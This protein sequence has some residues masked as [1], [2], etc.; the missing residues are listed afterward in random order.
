[1]REQEPM[2][3]TLNVNDAE[4]DFANLVRRVSKHETRVVVEEGGT[5]MAAIVSTEDLSRLTRI[6]QLR[7]K[8][9]EV[10][11]EIHALNHDK[12][13]DEV[14]RDVDETIAEM[15]EEDRR[16]RESRPSR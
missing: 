9:W 12:D 7:A 10:F 2:T 3:Q 1:M 14:E 13:P 6:D 11:E 8:E 4:R 15:R 5:P 16:K